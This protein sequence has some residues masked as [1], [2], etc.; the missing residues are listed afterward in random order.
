MGSA[1]YSRYAILAL[2]AGWLTAGMAAHSEQAR[3]SRSTPVQLAQV[4][5]DDAVWQAIADTDNEAMLEAFLKEYP[6]SRHAQAARTRLAALKRGVVPPPPVTVAPP[7]ADPKP[8][9]VVPKPPVEVKPP[10]APPPPRIV[11]AMPKEPVRTFP[12]PHIGP[13]DMNGLRIDGCLAWG[14]DCGKPAADTFCKTQG[15]DGAR[16]F[17]LRK[18]DAM[19]WLQGDMQICAGPGCTALTDVACEHP[20]RPPQFSVP[21]TI[22][23]PRV[24][25]QPLADCLY[26]G[27]ACGMATAHMYCRAAGFARAT[28]LTHSPDGTRALHLGD[29]K[30]CDGPKCRAITALFCSP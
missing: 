1:K 11:G 5:P 19:T 14:R 15:Y 25:H 17:E 28:R 6:N 16:T 4:D 29:A 13:E 23:D 12:K 7:R 20:K 8:P 24:N 21:E 26:A 10:D 22:R 30:V 3:P 18:T 9:V 27:D 2:L